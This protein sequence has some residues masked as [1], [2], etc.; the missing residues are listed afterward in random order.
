MRMKPHTGTGAHLFT[1]SEKSLLICRGS[2]PRFIETGASTH[3]RLMEHTMHNG[4]T[5]GRTTRSYVWV[6]DYWVS[7]YSLG[8]RHQPPATYMK[9]A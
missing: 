9:P 4:C 2:T 1:S 8:V 6:T 7:L 5:E 3:M